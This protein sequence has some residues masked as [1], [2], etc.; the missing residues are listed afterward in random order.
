V[1]Y[2]YGLTSYSLSLVII[3]VMLL[4]VI[5]ILWQVNRESPH[6]IIMPNI[7]VS[8]ASA[9]FD[10]YPTDALRKV[11]IKIGLRS[12]RL[13]VN[14]YN[15]IPAVIAYATFDV[16]NDGLRDTT[17]HECRVYSEL[18]HEKEIA[19]PIPLFDEDDDLEKAKKDQRLPKRKRLSCGERMTKGFEFG[20]RTNAVYRLELYTTELESQRRL[21]Y[22]RCNNQIAFC[23]TPRR[24]DEETFR[25]LEHKLKQL[26]VDIKPPI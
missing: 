17:V 12:Y 1:L 6:P 15:D 23:D 19:A 18:P 8:L 2:V 14:I 5:P 13:T 24:V 7:H 26:I 10:V 3:L 4:Q 25:K 9:H 16:G 11:K 21:V 22:F 20:S